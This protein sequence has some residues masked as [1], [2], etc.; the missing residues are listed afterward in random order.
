MD[1]VLTFVQ[2]LLITGQ[3]KI[4]KRRGLDSGI[5]TLVASILTKGCK[6]FRGIRA[7]CV[8]GCGQDGSILLRALFE[9]TIAMRYI[10][11]RNT[12]R[13]SIL[14]AAHEDFR[15]LVLVEETKR[16]PGQK[17]LFKNSALLQ[18]R[19]TMNAWRTLAPAAEV[20]SVRKHWAGPGGLEAACK[21]LGRRSGWPRAYVAMYRYVSAFSHGSDANAHMFLQ[22]GTNTP[23]FKL[24]PGTDELDRVLPMA[25]LLLL[26]MAGRFGE[27]LGLGI[28]TEVKA[29]NDQILAAAKSQPPR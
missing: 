1:E 7:A 23:V 6:T 5:V 21:K 4:T 11:Q 13:R 18:A 24:L 26:A 14:F 15:K 17:R 22:P 19:S 25:C 3:L 2:G 28:E 20:D 12:R 27:R 10:L 9:S 16:T 8:A 29:L